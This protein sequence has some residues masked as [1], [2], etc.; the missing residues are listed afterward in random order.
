M[1]LLLRPTLHARGGSGRLSRCLT[2][3]GRG[4]RIAPRLYGRDGV[5]LLRHASA[6]DRRTSASLDRSRRLDRTGRADAREL[7]EALAGHEIDRVVS[8]PLARCV[9]TVG[10]LAR[11]RNLRVEQHAELLPDAPVAEARR[12][13]DGLP[14]ATLVCVPCEVLS[15]LLGE[16]VTCEE[17]AAWE[18]VLGAGGFTTVAYFPPPSTLASATRPALL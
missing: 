7:P 10:A 2:K 1:R 4:S 14:A 6:G 16:D 12:L 11:S 9:E 8:S 18:V 5:L 17:G 15:R 13:L 3:E